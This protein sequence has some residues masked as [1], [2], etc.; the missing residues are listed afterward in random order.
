M[1]VTVRPLLSAPDSP[2]GT[3]GLQ[4]ALRLPLHAVPP[5]PLRW[6]SSIRR[7]KTSRE[8]KKSVIQVAESRAPS[9]AGPARCGRSRSPGSR[10]PPAMRVSTPSRPFDLRSQTSW[11]QVPTRRPAPLERPPGTPPPGR[12]VPLDAPSGRTGTLHERP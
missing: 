5:S 3:A 9:V 10:R 1:C 6:S 8:E 12:R 11:I 4:A 7:Q 2:P